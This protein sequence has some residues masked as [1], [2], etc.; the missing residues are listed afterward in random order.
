MAQIVEAC[1]P[2]AP[3]P[4][5]EQHENHAIMM[6][7]KLNAFRF[8][9]PIHDVEERFQVKL[10]QHGWQSVC[11]K[12]GLQ[13]FNVL[14]LQAMRARGELA[15]WN[16]EKLLVGRVI[17]ITKH[18][19]ADHLIIARIDYGKGR[20][21]SIVT[22]TPSLTYFLDKPLPRLHVPYAAPGAEVVDPSSP[23]NQRAHRTIQAMNFHGRLSEGMVCS[24]CEVGLGKFHYDIFL[25]PWEVAP[26]TPL[27][28][29]LGDAVVCIKMNASPNIWSRSS[30]EQVI[31]S[32]SLVLERE[33]AGFNH[34]A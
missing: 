14:D 10:S 22:S 32:I 6:K 27:S 2:V 19:D 15:W 16:S 13:A 25:L 3:P 24:E 12:A 29:C 20:T 34:H 30:R 17:A 23:R 26:G 21:A 9:V 33:L 28:T 7:N 1:G 5:Q 4:S 18:P 8:F 11:R 31:E